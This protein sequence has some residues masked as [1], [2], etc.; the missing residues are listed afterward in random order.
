MTDNIPT[1]DEFRDRLDAYSFEHRR[2]NPNLVGD[3][4]DAINA[5]E[6]REEQFY[7][8]SGELDEALARGDGLEF[9]LH[10]RQRTITRLK[11]ALHE[12]AINEVSMGGL[13]T[14][15][16]FKCNVCGESSSPDKQP[17]GHWPKVSPLENLT[18]DNDCLLA[19]FTP[20]ED[21]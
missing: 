18:H 21:S 5:L 11:A 13:R 20:E 14:R 19:G 9:L 4:E 17:Y 12:H 6:K 2:A 3:F 16:W 15:K 1:A 10:K 8:V 7:Q